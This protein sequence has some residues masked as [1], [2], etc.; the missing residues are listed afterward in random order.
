MYERPETLGRGNGMVI[1]NKYSQ[2]LNKVKYLFWKLVCSGLTAWSWSPRTAWATCRWSSRP[3]GSRCRRRRRRRS[4][5][6]E[7]S[8][9]N[10]S[11]R[12]PHSPPCRNKE[13]RSRKTFLKL[14][15]ASE[16]LNRYCPSH[17]L[18]SPLTPPSRLYFKYLK[19]QVC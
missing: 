10:T 11:H 2:I 9:A 4:T 6:T 17:P 16:S 5:C 15:I 19:L 3:T 7:K 8:S 14:K 18:I 1:P 13:N 12:R